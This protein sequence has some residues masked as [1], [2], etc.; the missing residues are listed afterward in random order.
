MQ[1]II[2]IVLLVT[3]MVFVFVGCGKKENPVTIDELN[4]IN[5]RIIDYYRSVDYI[6]E[7]GEYGNLSFNYV[8]TTNKVV[9]VGLLNNSKAQ[10]DRFKKLVVDSEYIR[11]VQGENLIDHSKK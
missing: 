9:V 8:D 3:M 10:Q 5:N 7:N 2:L 4:D 1:K 6:V 11:F